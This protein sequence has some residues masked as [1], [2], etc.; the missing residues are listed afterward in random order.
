MPTPMLKVLNMSR[1]GMLPVSCDQVEDGQHGHGALL[2]LARVRPVGQAAGDVLIEAAA[3]DV[4]DG[5][6]RDTAP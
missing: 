3:G 4:G 6:D 2:D 1:S 5:L